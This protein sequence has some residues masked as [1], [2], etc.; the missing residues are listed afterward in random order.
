ML[1]R[2][3]TIFVPIDDLFPI[4]D[5]TRSYWQALGRMVD[6]FSTVETVLNFVVVKYANLDVVTSRALLLPLRVDAA[7]NLI[8]KLIEGKKLK[9]NNIDE[10]KCILQQL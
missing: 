6:M 3:K 9:G 10:V 7:S 2:R 1:I 4:T 5:A 8:H